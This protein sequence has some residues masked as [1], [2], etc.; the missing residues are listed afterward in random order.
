MTKKQFIGL[1][2]EFYE[3]PFDHQARVSLERTPVLRLLLKKV[4]EYGID[5]LLRMQITGC[6]F[7]VT[8]RNFPRLND[9]FLEACNILNI[10]PIPELFLFRGTGYIKAYAVGVEKPV[11]GINLEGME[12][13][14]HDE[15]LFVFGHEVAKIKGKYLAYQQMAH[16]MPVVKNLISSTTLGIGGLAVNGIEI[17]LYNWMIMSKFTAD[18]AGLLACQNVDVAI[19]ALMKLGGLPQEYLN[20]DT[21]NDFVIQARAFEFNNLDSLDQF[22]KTFSF[23]EHLLPWTVMRASELLKWV[24]SGDYEN[25]REGKE[26]GSQQ[27]E[28]QEDDENWNFLTAWDGDREEVIGDR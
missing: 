26:L 8:P 5:K 9:A 6:E 27:P 23:M 18:R 19:T 4:N 12:W 13:L 28:N 21:I 7:K 17:A 24:D 11:V 3:H 14:S 25:L 10:N 16:V 1:E 2:T 22:A 15:L 20:E